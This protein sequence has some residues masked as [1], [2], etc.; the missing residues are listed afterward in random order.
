MEWIIKTIE[1]IKNIISQNVSAIALLLGVCIGAWLA[2]RRSHKQQKLDF[3]EKQLREFYSPLVGIRKEIRILSEFRLAGENASRE[4]WQKVC[5]YAKQIKDP[6]KAEKYYGKEGEKIKTQIEYEN[7][8][9]TEKIIPSYRKMIDTFK[10]SYW[11]AEEET[12]EYFPTLIKF[13]EAWERFLSE[14][15]HPDVLEDIKVKEEELI[16]FYEHIEA[17]H[18]SLRGKLKK[19]KT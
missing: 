5:E 10:E 9:L 1:W 16:P 13:V 19:G 7:K 15:H 8:Q 14:T 11:L 4:W 18:K 2:K 17:I 6:D 12:K 3:Y